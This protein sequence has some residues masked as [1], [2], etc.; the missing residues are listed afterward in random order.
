[1]QSYD[2]KLSLH[3]PYKSVTETRYFALLDNNA[4]P[5]LES[6]SYKLGTSQMKLNRPATIAIHSDKQDYS[7]YHYRDDEWHELITFSEDGVLTAETSALGKFKLD[8]ATHT[9]KSS[10]LENN[11]PN[12]FNSSTQISF[13]VGWQDAEKWVTLNIYNIN[14]QHVKTLTNKR[15]ASGTY[16][17]VWNGVDDIGAHLASGIY[18]SVLKIG[19]EKHLTKRLILLK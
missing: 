2:K 7:I 8:V 11:Y 16:S 5:Q 13:V 1:L 3:V 12:P 18:F 14:G 9:P 17:I 15:Y 19:S 6:G 10:S 4:D